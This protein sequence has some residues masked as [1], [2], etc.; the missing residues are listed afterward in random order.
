MDPQQHGQVDS[1]FVVLGPDA[2]RF[3]SSKSI[4]R[5]INI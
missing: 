1:D 3:A 2:M 5:G 4:K